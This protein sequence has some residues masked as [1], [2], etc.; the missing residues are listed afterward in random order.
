MFRLATI[1]F[2]LISTTLM[3]T[4]VIIALT[5]GYDSLNPILIAAAS[6]AVLALPATYLVTRAMT[7]R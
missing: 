4:G 7:G 2:S 3:G 5:L 1:L 6:G